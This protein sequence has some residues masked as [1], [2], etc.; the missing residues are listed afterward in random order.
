M[1]I[2]S[3]QAGGQA[4][5]RGQWPRAGGLHE[6]AGG[7]VLH[8]QLHADRRQLRRQGWRRVPGNQADVWELS[9]FKV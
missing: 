7:P 1:L 6:S 5:A 8:R 9:G 4:G 2:I 3:I